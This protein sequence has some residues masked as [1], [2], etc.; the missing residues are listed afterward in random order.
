MPRTKQSVR[1]PE[2]KSKQIAKAFPQAREGQS[3]SMTAAKKFVSVSHIKQAESLEQLLSRSEAEIS[4]LIL[5]HKQ[6]S[7]TINSVDCSASKLTD[8]INHSR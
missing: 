5:P 7:I 8:I 1:S 2:I 6:R 4:N 3:R